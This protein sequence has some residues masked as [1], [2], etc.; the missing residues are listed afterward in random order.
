MEVFSTPGGAG[1]K[2]LKVLLTQASDLW[3][4][5]EESRNTTLLLLSWC[6]SVVQ[7]DLLPSPCPPS[8]EICA[9]SRPFKASDA[10][11]R[12]LISLS[13]SSL[14]VAARRSLGLAVELLASRLAPSERALLKHIL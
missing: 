11:G 4:V 8:D 9:A 10:P 3:H 12:D 6:I 5:D 14:S 7:G 1:E 13:L 2:A